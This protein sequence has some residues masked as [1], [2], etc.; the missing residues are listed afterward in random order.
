VN[1]RGYH[2]TL[3]PAGVHCEMRV[4]FFQRLHVK[5]S[6]LFREKHQ[7]AVATTDTA[8]KHMLSPSVGS[9]KQIVISF[10]NAFI[11]A[12]DGDPV[13]DIEEAPIA[14]PAVKRENEKQ[15]FMD[16]HVLSSKGVH[17][18]IEMQ[19]KRHVMFD[20]RCLFYACSTFSRQLSEKDLSTRQWYMNLKPVIALQILD[21]DSNRARGLKSDFVGVT[22]SLIARVKDHPLESGQYTKHYEVVDRISGQKIKHL[23]MVQVELPRAEET[24]ILFPPNRNFTMAQWW[25]SLL[26]HSNDYTDE[27]I[28]DLVSTN[29]MPKEIHGALQRL[30]LTA[31][32]PQEVT[33]YKEDLIDKN[34]FRTVIAT[35]RQEG[36][37]DVA[38]KMKLEKLDVEM[39]IK[40]TGLSRAEIEDISE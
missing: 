34:V 10:L 8:F 26:K 39:I 37:V 9:N 16:M 14:L 19:A 33:E 31:W 2:V 36:I 20:E 17:Y 1:S 4:Q 28:N 5:P 13:Q 23:Q 18:I 22:D 30:D 27:V 25:L 3:K 12:F 40:L 29:V 11:P 15:T 6:F 21:Y 38:R 35:A 7:Y 24:Q 32:N